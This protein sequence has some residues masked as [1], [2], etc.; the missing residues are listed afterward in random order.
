MI[1]NPISVIMYISPTSGGLVM[2]LVHLRYQFHFAPAAH[3]M[4]NGKNQQLINH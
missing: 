4:Y 3:V 2:Y 1:S